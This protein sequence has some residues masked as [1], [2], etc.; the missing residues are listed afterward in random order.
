MGLAKFGDT[1]Y[2]K[3]N[4]AKFGGGIISKHTCFFIGHRNVP[5]SLIPALDELVERHITEYGVREFTVGRY[6]RF[7]YLAATAVQRA[8]ERHPDVRLVYLRP[9]HP[10]ERPTE[11]PK[12]FDSSFY[13]FV[14]EKVPKRLAIIRANRYMVDHS[15]Y[16]IAHA[17]HPG[18]ARE[19]LEYAKAR[20]RKGL[21][22]I[23]NLA[24]NA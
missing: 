22:H 18:N 20:E 12:G 19:L 10:G 1:K 7:D 2:N 4:H 6:G 15:D 24:G 14:N 5:D 17:R 11:T 8:K 3:F 21:I 16:L 9:Y 23:E 13:P